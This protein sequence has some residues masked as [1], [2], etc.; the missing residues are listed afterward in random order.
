[1]KRT[2]ATFFFLTLIAALWPG[3]MAQE[4][5]RAALV[6]VL[7]GGEAV[8]R[9]VAFEEAQI[10]GFELLNQSGLAV[11][12]GGGSLGAAVCRIEETGCPAGN[13]FCQ[14]SG[15][16]C[17][18]WSYWHLLEGEWRY[19]QV[20]ASLYQVEDGAVEGWSWGPSAPNEALPPPLLAFEEVCVP[21][22][23]APEAVET[24]PAGVEATAVSQTGVAVSSGQLLAYGLF[25]LLLAGLVVALLVAQRRSRS[26]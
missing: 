11:E 8:T 2:T 16:D 19:S 23:A 3:V 1:M 7:D 25:G 24:A 17:E 4:A 6:V 13:C 26:G 20:G 14:C 9:C 5:N 12:A 22:A 15:D 10:S 18:Y 21:A